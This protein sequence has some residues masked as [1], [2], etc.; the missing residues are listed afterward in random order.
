MNKKIKYIIN[1]LVII[2]IL[3]SGI[4]GFIKYKQSK[5]KKI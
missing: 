4:V 2:L 3:A 5:E 1:T